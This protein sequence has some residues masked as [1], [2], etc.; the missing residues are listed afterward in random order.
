MQSQKMSYL[1]AMTISLWLNDKHHWP[2]VLV[3]SATG[4]VFF[5]SWYFCP[6]FSQHL[7][8]II[9]NSFLLNGASIASYAGCYLVEDSNCF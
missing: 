2:V 4:R 8:P 6:S 3:Q 5:L 9:V 1:S 7:H